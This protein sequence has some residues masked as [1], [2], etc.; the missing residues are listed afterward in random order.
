MPENALNSKARIIVMADAALE[1]CMCGVWCGFKLKEGGWSCQLLIARSMLV[2][3]TSATA[4]T[5]PKN[6]LQAL[7]SASNLGRV[8]E[9]ALEDWVEEKI[10]ASDSTIALSWA[11]AEMKPLAMFHKN[12]VVE[13]LRG[14]SKEQLYHA[15]TFSLQGAGTE[16]PQVCYEE[17]LILKSSFWAN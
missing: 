10:V 8:V 9:K 5:I 2:S 17:A 16:L 13:I 6:E 12:R 3:E 4:A 15:G 11:M 1:V 7:C 14:T